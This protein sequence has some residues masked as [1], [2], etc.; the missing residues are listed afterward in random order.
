MLALLTAFTFGAVACGGG[1]I[2]I[3][4]VVGPP[5]TTAGTY[6]ITVTGTSGAL[7][8]TGTVTLTVQ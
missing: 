4:N 7:T 5:P 3:C 6:T 8:E 2:P 1:T